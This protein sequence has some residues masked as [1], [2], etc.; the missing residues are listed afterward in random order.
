M[1]VRFIVKASK[2]IQQKQKMHAPL[3]ANYKQL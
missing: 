2:K 1:S 3:I